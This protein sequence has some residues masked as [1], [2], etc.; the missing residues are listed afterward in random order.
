[1]IIII[2]S[3]NKVNI[4]VTYK[5]RNSVGDGVKHISQAIYELKMLK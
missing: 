5:R 3:L 4:Y 2:Y 1:M